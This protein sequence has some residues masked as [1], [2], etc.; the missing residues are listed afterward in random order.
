MLLAGIAPCC[1]LLGVDMRVVV[2]LIGSFLVLDIA[3]CNYLHGYMYFLP[4]SIDV[5]PLPLL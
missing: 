1:L 4:T 2:D 3:L 5:V